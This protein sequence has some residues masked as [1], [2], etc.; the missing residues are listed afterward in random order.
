M[1]AVITHFV[2]VYYGGGTVVDGEPEPG[3]A[4]EVLKERMSR[5]AFLRT[6]YDRMVVRA[7]VI[8]RA[9]TVVAGAD[10]GAS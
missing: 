6:W 2:R 8:E 3:P 1:S 4:S 10:R 9:E 7:E 5:P